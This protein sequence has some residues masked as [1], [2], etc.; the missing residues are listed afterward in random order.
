MSIQSFAPRAQA[1]WDLNLPVGGAQPVA[2]AATAPAAPVTQA[3]Q[4]ADP[5]ANWSPKG[6][7]FDYAYDAYVFSK[8]PLNMGGPEF[9]TGGQAR[10][11]LASLFSKI[12]SDRMITLAVREQ[13]MKVQGMTPDHARVLQMAYYNHLNSDPTLRN[14]PPL[15]WLAQ[16]GAGGTMNDW[17]VRGPLIVEMNLIAGQVALQNGWAPDVPGNGALTNYGAAASRLLPP[18]APNVPVAPTR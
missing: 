7:L 4:Q 18:V 2:P 11:K 9:W 3:P 17:L 5:W 14:T 12:P 10:M 13:F 16:Y 15:N 8:F 6:Q 1:N